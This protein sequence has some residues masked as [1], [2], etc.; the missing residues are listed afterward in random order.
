[1][2]IAKI[3]LKSVT[4]ENKIG[5]YN[6]FDKIQGIPKHNCKFTIWLPITVEVTSSILQFLAEMVA[7][8]TSFLKKRSY[9]Q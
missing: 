7:F 8:A 1:M 3:E 9:L 2:K 4:S 5:P 6:I